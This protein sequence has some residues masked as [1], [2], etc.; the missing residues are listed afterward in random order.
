MA[1]D[2]STNPIIAQE[3]GVVISSPSSVRSIQWVNDEGD[4]IADASHLTLT[5]NGATFTVD[6]MTAV[7]GPVAWEMGPFNPGIVVSGLSVDAMAHGSLHVWV[8]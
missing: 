4:D 6:M 8:S 1:I 3:T 5:I 2:K 7:G